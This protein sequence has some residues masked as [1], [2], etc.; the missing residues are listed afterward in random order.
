MNPPKAIIFDLDD[1][2]LAWS[3]TL[4]D[5]WVSLCESNRDRLGDVSTLP[6]RI[7]SCLSAVR[8]D[9]KVQPEDQRRH[10][11]V[12]AFRYEGLDAP[13]LV[14][15]FIDQYD[16]ARVEASTLFPGARETLQYFKSRNVGLAL[17]TSGGAKPQ[18]RKLIK[19][20]LEAFFDIILIDGEIGYGKPD[21]PVY[22]E[23]LEQ[24]AVAPE[25][26]WCVGDGLEW[27]LETAQRL[28]MFGIWVTWPA[29]KYIYMDLPSDAWPQNC[30]V[31]PDLI[32]RHVS[33][34]MPVDDQAE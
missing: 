29:E 34:L 31:K 4:F 13:D 32:V 17:L 18:R 6:N 20:D 27:D 19:H 3:A 15:T 5:A 21:E 14:D 23:A 33:D 26:T 30:R 8:L 11:I 1:T 24:L 12:R 22:R 7:Q 16:G 25:D 9:P 2:L 28:G 10:A